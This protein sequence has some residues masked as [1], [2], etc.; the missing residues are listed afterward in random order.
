MGQMPKILRNEDSIEQTL[1]MVLTKV[2]HEMFAGG[3]CDL[4]HMYVVCN[5]KIT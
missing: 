5:Y 3:A 1:R 2:V 4:S